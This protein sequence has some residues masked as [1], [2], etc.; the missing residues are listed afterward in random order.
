MRTI[1]AMAAIVA[2]GLAVGCSND[3]APCTVGRT[4]E[5]ACTDGSTG[6]QVCGDDHTFAPCVCDSEVVD[7][8]RRDAD[9][10][11]GDPDV[12]AHDL[13]DDAALDTPDETDDTDETDETDADIVDSGEP[14]IEVTDTD[15]DGRDGDADAAELDLVDTVDADIVDSDAADTDGETGD[16]ED[17][18]TTTPAPEPIRRLVARN[19]AAIARR[20]EPVTVGVPFARGE[21]FDIEALSLLDPADRVLPLQRRISSQWPDGSVRWLLLDFQAR[22]AAD[23]Q[24]EYRLVAE[25]AP[26]IDAPAIEIE[27]SDEAVIV[28]TG[29]AR[30]LF[31]EGE[32]PIF[33]RVEVGEVVA[34]AID[35]EGDGILADISGPVGTTT[36]TITVEARGPNRATVRLE[37]TVG[38]RLRFDLRLHFYAGHGYVRALHTLWNPAAAI[39]RGNVWHLGAGGHVLM[40]DLSWA[41]QVA[42]DGDPLIRLWTGD[43]PGGDEAPR[44]G[45]ARLYQDS[46][47]GAQWDSDNHVNRDGRVP[48]TFRGYRV[49]AAGLTLAEGLRAQPWLEVGDEERSVAVGVRWAWQNF[50][51]AFEATT[52]GLLRVGLWP[53]EFDDLHEIQGGEQKTHEL[54]FWFRGPEDADPPT[55]TPFLQEPL[56]AL[57]SAADLL[58]TGVFRPAEPAREGPLDDYET[59]IR[60]LIVAQGDEP[61]S[62][63]TQREVIDEYGWRNF[64]D[65]LA[66]HESI[67]GA[68]SRFL[69]PISHYNNQYDMVFAGMLHM[70]RTGDDR[71]RHL[72]EPAAWH[73]ADIDTY[74]TELD[75][76]AYNGGLFWHTT[77]DSHAYRSTHRTYPAESAACTRYSSGGPATGHIYVDGLWLYYGLTG[78]ERIREVALELSEYGLRRFR[79]DGSAPARGVANLLRTFVLA[80]RETGDDQWLTGIDEVLDVYLPIAPDANLSNFGHGMAA[81]GLAMVVELERDRGA[82]DGPRARLA[83]EGLFDAADRMV[84]TVAPVSGPLG[85]WHADGLLRAYQFAPGDHP[86]R[87]A[88]Y[89]HAAAL[90][91]A[92]VANPWYTDG[93]R[94]TYITLK[95]L[96]HLSSNGHLMPW[97][98]AVPPEVRDA[99]ELLT[100]EAQPGRVDVLVGATARLGLYAEHT[101]RTWRP[102]A[103]PTSCTSDDPSIARMAD[104]G[105]R[106][107]GVVAGETRVACEAGGLSVEIEVAVE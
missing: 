5:C 103:V 73:T 35:R 6:A 98:A 21:L 15:A 40:E 101:D 89:D 85:M 99:P 1:R 91:E 32:G 50:P 65:A 100:L 68:H 54:V 37:G 64:G 70:A 86:S 90:F 2:F 41:L 72:G 104:T 71:F 78:H 92:V 59:Q 58:R 55:L 11:P 8:S 95:V 96:L 106:V 77:H 14:D 38:S 31:A 88:W 63:L 48:V 57:P 28:D 82:Y 16:A 29:R 33:R 53:G 9:G 102:P 25:D 56:W 4:A 45:V 23:D 36:E 19:P 26:A 87:D 69:G 27:D 97:F 46:S 18:D 10:G 83:R 3:P 105:D 74:H 66:D 42:V 7:S 80:W 12:P 75:T 39:H 47:G 34:L 20:D 79:R 52:G 62:V 17:G 24:T 44:V 30:F 84:A 61:R 76:P 94:L 81:K 60:S 43:D 67:C 49:D 107:I 13:E 22:V 51:K 93:P